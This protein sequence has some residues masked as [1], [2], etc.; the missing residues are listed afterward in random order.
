[1]VICVMISKGSRNYNGSK[2][3]PQGCFKYEEMTLRGITWNI[4]LRRSKLFYYSIIE[5][6]S[7]IRTMA[8]TRDTE[9]NK[10]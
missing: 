9:I 10:T 1:M 2:A 8:G 4:G 7:W 5:N 3:L 6:I